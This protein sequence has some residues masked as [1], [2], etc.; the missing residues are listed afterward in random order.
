MFKKTIIRN[1]AFVFIIMVACSCGENKYSPKFNTEDILGIY[2]VEVV[3]IDTTAYNSTELLGLTLCDFIYDFQN[4]SVGITSRM[5]GLKSDKRFFVWEIAND[6]IRIVK[7]KG[8][9]I[10][11]VSDT[12]NGYFLKGR[13]SSMVMKKAN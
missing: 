2:E 3:D 9:S 13:L 4:D 10:Y 7:P 6:T 8:T 12:T 5:G 11:S 1:A